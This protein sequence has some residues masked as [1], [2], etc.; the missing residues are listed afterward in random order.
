[1]THKIF[2]QETLDFEVA[3]DECGKINGH[4][5]VYYIR[6]KGCRQDAGRPII[7][8]NISLA[9]KYEINPRLDSVIWLGRK[10]ECYR[11]FIWLL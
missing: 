7:F 9:F 4:I 5:E 11:D 6:V 3:A 1:M 10:T 8:I 2:L